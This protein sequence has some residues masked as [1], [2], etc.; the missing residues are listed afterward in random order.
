M[1]KRSNGFVKHRAL[2]NSKRSRSPPICT[3]NM[4]STSSSQPLLVHYWLRVDARSAGRPQW[5]V[6]RTTWTIG[7]DVW[8]RLVERM[9]GKWSVHSPWRCAFRLWF[10][11]R[12]M[13]VKG[14]ITCVPLLLSVSFHTTTNGQIHPSL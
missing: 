7:H 3:S 14:Y 11:L 9:A 5:T 8:R 1:M 13:S 4:N 2:V 6:P 10:W 12:G